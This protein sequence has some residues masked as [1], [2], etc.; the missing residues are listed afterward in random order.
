MKA[1][2][3]AGLFAQAVTVSAQAQTITTVNPVVGPNR[4]PFRNLGSANSDERN[5]NGNA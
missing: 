3:L 1:L 5:V 2:I 4:C